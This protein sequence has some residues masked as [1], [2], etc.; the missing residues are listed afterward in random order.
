VTERLRQS[1]D[2]ITRVR[3][4]RGALLV[5]GDDGLIV[6]DAVMDSVRGDAV[7]ALGANLATRMA[8][9]CECSGVGSLQFVHLQSVQGTLLVMP[10]AEEVVLVVI[11]DKDI[12]V[13]LVRLE[14]QGMSEAVP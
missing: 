14:M 1:L 9:T 10:L 3:G 7:A 12:N 5:T 8:K 13:G 4:V 11:G 6:A 2:K